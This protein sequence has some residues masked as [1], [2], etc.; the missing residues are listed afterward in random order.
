MKGTTFTAQCNATPP[1]ESRSAPIL[2]WNGNAQ[3]GGFCKFDCEWARRL[4]WV[5]KAVMIGSNRAVCQ[6]RRGLATCQHS[7]VGTQ[8][9]R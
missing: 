9:N 5:G 1:S 2:E 6:Q 8:N 3:A 7:F 4:G